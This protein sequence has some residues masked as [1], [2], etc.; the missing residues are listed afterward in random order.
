MKKLVTLALLLGTAAVTSA[1]VLKIKKT[2]D[3]KA[4]ITA[5]L[6]PVKPI[7]L[8]AQGA[9]GLSTER[10]HRLKAQLRVA[11][12]H[13]DPQQAIVF[14]QF[15]KVGDPQK[16]QAMLETYREKGYTLRADGAYWT[17]SVQTVADP[18][19][20]LNALTDVAHI[21]HTH[22]MTHHGFD[23]QPALEKP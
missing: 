23:L 8:T 14:D 19:V 12:E 1:I 10:L 2:T 9:P 18:Q 13:H 11:C 3:R 4:A 15:V 16:A 7:S 20:L 22:R 21:A 5:P 6:P 17:V